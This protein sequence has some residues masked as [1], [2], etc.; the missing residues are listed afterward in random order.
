MEYHGAAH[1]RKDIAVEAGYVAMSGPGRQPHSPPHRPP[2]RRLYPGSGKRDESVGAF[3]LGIS[4]ANLSNATLSS[5][6]NT[7]ISALTTAQKAALASVGLTQFLPYS[8]FP[9][10]QTVRQAL[11]PYPQYTGP[12]LPWVHPTRKAGTTR[13]S[14]NLR[15][16][17]PRSDANANY[18]YS[19]NLA[20]IGSPDPFNR[21]LGKTL[22]PMT[23]APTPVSAQ[24]EVRA[25]APVSSATKCSATWCP[26]GYGL[27][28]ELPKR[29]FV[30]FP[31][32]PA[33]RQ[34]AISSVTDRARRN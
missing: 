17:Q 32:V 24:Y 10:N 1:L 13:S 23:S 2:P 26:G 4:G 29:V 27:V 16:V 6:F 19:K 14:S 12:W 7:S 5:A 20:L 15:S 18:T 33:P 30:A 28:S 31:P 9:Q 3:R 22:S 11:L 21:S 25:L 34:S 8:N